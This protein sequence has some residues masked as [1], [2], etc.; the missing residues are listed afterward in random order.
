MMRS[1]MQLK[2]G[3]GQAIGQLSTMQV[4]SFHISCK[5]TLKFQ[6]KSGTEG[7]VTPDAQVVEESGDF[8]ELEEEEEEMLPAQRE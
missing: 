3:T 4:Y 2:P 1:R 7:K 6:S 5:L 8:T